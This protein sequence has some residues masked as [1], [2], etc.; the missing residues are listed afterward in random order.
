MQIIEQFSVWYVDLGKKEDIKGHEQYGKRPFLVISDT[1]YNLASKTPMGFI[2]SSSKKK[3]N[4][5]FTL[6]ID[7]GNNKENS[8]INI[9]QIRTLSQDRFI[10]KLL[11][12]MT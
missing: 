10:E 5:D 8:H 2:G 6:R 3:N 7:L 12:M 9:S 4:N 1:S 11:L